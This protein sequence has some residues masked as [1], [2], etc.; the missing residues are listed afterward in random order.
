MF[1]TY[2]KERRSWIFLFIILQGLIVFIT[3]IDSTI[4]VRPILYYVFISTI[5]FAIFLAIRFLKETKF[6]LALKERDDALD[7]T[8]IPEAVSPFEEIVAESIH[9]HSKRFKK[10]LMLVR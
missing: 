2:L 8:S 7:L 4:S 9:L 1:N 3:Y 5:I 10:R 6:Y